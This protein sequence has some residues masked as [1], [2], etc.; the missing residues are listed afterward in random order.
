[1]N[2]RMTQEFKINSGLKQGCN[3][4]QILFKRYLHDIIQE[5]KKR[6]ETVNK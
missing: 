4:S 5:Y 6:E 1:M 2:E 3:L